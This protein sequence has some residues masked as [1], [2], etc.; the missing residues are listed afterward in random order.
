VHPHDI[1]YALNFTLPLIPHAA[2]LWALSSLS[3]PTMAAVSTLEQVGLLSI[4]LN[5]AQIAGMVLAES[6][7]AALPR[8]SREI[9]PAPTR[10]TLEPVRWQVIGAL[11]VPAVVGCGIA[12]GG[13]WIFPEDYWPSFALTGVLLISQAAY[14]LY[15]IPMNY[16][17]QTAG[18][19]RLSALASGTGAAVILVSILVLG[20]RYG[21]VGAAYATAAGYLTMAA[22]AVILTMVQ[23]LDIA[24]RSWLANW[25]KFVLA[26]GAL[27]CSVAALASPVGSPLS[28]TLTAACLVLALSAFI[29]TARREYH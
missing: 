23:K 11:V 29:V 3:R 6:N 4:G 15:L 27:T 18:L 24:W 16:L 19:P 25:P 8:Y 26:A 1:R 12:V 13:Q 2:S 17:T 14:G 7:R 10:E 21:A 9:L 28:W 5:L 20:H 22:V